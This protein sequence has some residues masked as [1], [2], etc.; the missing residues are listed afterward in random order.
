MSYPFERST[1]ISSMLAASGA[2]SRTIRTALFAIAAGSVAPGN[3]TTPTNR[4]CLELLRPSSM[5]MTVGAL[6]LTYATPG[7]FEMAC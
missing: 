2:V 6:I 3:R 1:V 5:L 4:T 7:S